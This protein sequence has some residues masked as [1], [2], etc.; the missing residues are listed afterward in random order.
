MKIVVTVTSPSG[1]DIAEA[2]QGMID[3]L[4]EEG[5]VRMLKNRLFS[6]NPSLRRGDCQVSVELLNDDLTA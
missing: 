6:R 4:G 5:A 1:S 2:S 3:L